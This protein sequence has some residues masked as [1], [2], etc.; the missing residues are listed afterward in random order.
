MRETEKDEFDDGRSFQNLDATEGRDKNY[1]SGKPSEHDPTLLECQLIH[2]DTIYR[3]ALA[4]LTD[5]NG[6]S[7]K[8][9][10]YLKEL[11][12]DEHAEEMAEIIQK[13]ANRKRRKLT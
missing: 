12:P 7:E 2:R 1:R 10:L 13:W 5:A 6:I 8:A 3:L 9:Y 11:L 4:L